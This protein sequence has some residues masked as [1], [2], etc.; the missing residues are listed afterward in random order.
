MAATSLDLVDDRLAFLVSKLP[1][2]EILKIALH[3]IR[4][5][6]ATSVRHR[7]P[8]RDLPAAAVVRERRAA[9]DRPAAQDLLVAVAA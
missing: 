5:D 4:N 7:T 9:L 2:E 8:R 1:A 3:G 6:A